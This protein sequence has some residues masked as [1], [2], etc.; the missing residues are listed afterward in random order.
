MNLS[1]DSI[2]RL[3]AAMAANGVHSVRCVEDGDSALT[4]QI[5][6]EPLLSVDEVA[7]FIG[8]NAATVRRWTRRRQ[9]TA[10]R[11]PSGEYRYDR[12]TL[13]ADLRAWF[14]PAIPGGV[15]GKRRKA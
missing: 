14:Q 12:A 8:V 9:L 10:I 4:F 3:S 5:Q 7:S 1:A 15:S 2:A 11:T 13:M 6:R